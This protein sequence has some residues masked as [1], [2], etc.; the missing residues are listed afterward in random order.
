MAFIPKISSKQKDV[1]EVKE[2]VMQFS[3][4]SEKK[5]EKRSKISKLA[6]SLRCSEKKVKNVDDSNYCGKDDEQ[7]RSKHRR[8]SRSLRRSKDGKKERSGR[9]RSRTRS[10][11]KS[12][13]RSRRRQTIKKANDESKNEKNLLVVTSKEEDEHEPFLCGLTQGLTL[14]C[15]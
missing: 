1:T 4:N 2:D 7:I 8:R 14:C 12:R 6:S 5:D 9:S 10:T 3:P 13:S 15:V 11:S